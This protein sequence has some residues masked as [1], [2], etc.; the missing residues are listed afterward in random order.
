MSGKEILRITQD[1]ARL[2]ATP[3]AQSEMSASQQAE[4]S[5]V[6]NSNWMVD[7]SK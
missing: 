1:L 3:M 7:A 5:N 4:F 2:G 6:I